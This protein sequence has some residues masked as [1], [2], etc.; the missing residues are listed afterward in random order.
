MT[1][2]AAKYFSGLLLYRNPVVRFIQV[3]RLAA[4]VEI[5]PRGEFAQGR[6]A[7]R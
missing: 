5:Y 3:E 4:F 2:I 7:Q 6:A 1:T